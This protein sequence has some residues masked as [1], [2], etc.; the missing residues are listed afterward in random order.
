M[1]D[2]VWY[3]D[4]IRV[5]LR[6][7]PF[8]DNY[9]ALFQLLGTAA[10]ESA[11]TYTHQL[12]NGV[13]R[14]YFQC[15]PA[16]EADIWTNYLA[17]QPVLREVFLRRCGMTGPNVEALEHNMV[18]GILLARTHYYRCDPEPLP[19]AHDVPEAARRWKQWYNTPLGA[20]TTDAYLASY[21]TL[22]APYY[23]PRAAV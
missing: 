4:L 15:E 23:P 16:T 12:G 22:V 20:G 19:P 21:A 18:Y 9:R 11:F 1:L 14:G 17:Y 13:A 6:G 8:P 5:T 3:G 7:G 10:Q 2:V